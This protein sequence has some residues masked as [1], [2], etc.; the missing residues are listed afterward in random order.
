MCAHHEKEQ[1]PSGYNNLSVVALTIL[2]MG[3]TTENF[4]RTIW[5]TIYITDP[6]VLQTPPSLRNSVNGSSNSNST[7]I[8]NSSSR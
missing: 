4:K 1:E 7:S 2:V 8:G 3:T 6:T 5:I